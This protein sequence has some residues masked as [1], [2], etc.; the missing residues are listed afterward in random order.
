[1]PYE[2]LGENSNIVKFA[3]MF[4]VYDYVEADDAIQYVFKWD[5]RRHNIADAE[6]KGRFAAALKARVLAGGSLDRGN[7]YIRREEI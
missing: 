2:L 6:P 7:G 1:M 5:T 3:A 4:N